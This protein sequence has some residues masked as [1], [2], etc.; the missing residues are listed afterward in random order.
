MIGAAEEAGLLRDDDD[1]SNFF[2]LEPEAASLYYHNSLD[3]YNN[4]NNFEEPFI[5]CDF[6]AGTVDIVTQKKEKTKD[7]IK[8][9]ELYEPIGG[10]NGCN[11]INEWFMDEYIKELFGEECFNNTKKTTCLNNYNDWIE[12]EH[13]IEDFKQRLVNP[14]Q[15]NLPYKI[16]LEIFSDY[17][18]AKNI[19]LAELIIKFNKNHIDCQLNIDRSWKILFP[20]KIMEDLMFRLVNKILEYIINIVQSMEINNVYIK[21]LILTG[22]GSLSPILKQMIEGNEYLKNIKCV[23][24]R[25]PKLA[26]SHGAILYA[27]DHNIIS[28]RKAKYSFGIK[29]RQ[30]WNEEIHRNGGKLIVEDNENICENCFSKFITKNE[31]IMSDQII[32]KNYEMAFSKVTVEL[33]KTEENNVYFCDE[34]DKNGNNKAD[35]FGEFI[36]DVGNNFNPS[37]R[38]AIV[39]MKMGGT[40]ISAWAIYCA[41]GKNAKIK[42]LYE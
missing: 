7:G 27:Y 8:F 10:D 25:Y 35:K 31:D 14:D 16:D 19:E 22:G 41:T 17:C 18:N 6:G 42:C 30:K 12:L 9:K 29:A 4:I 13:K 3:S 39:K 37:K 34:K 11:K 32:T 33:Y 40:F 36:I 24:S 20:Y 15:L 21:Y 1:P 28:P 26:I 38:N 23:Q 2:A 5:V